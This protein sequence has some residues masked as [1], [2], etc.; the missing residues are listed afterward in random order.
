[1]ART[2]TIAPGVP[3]VTVTSR[4]PAPLVDA[5]DELAAE[6]G[7]SRAAVIRDAVELLTDPAQLAATV[8]L[9]LAGAKAAP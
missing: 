7:T 3:L 4:L 9:T 1:M 6:Q 2:P 5:I 8:A